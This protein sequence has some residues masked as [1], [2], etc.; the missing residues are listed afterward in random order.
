MLEQE[1]PPHIEK[2]VWRNPI[3]Y[4]DPPYAEDVDKSDMLFV[5]QQL[6]SYKS[7]DNYRCT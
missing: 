1:L 6:C 2:K 7:K 4:T 3:Y 5:H